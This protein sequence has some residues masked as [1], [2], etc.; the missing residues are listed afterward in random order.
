MRISLPDKEKNET[1]FKILNLLE[2]IKAELLHKVVFI[3]VGLQWN[4]NND[5]LTA[6]NLA[7]LGCV[8]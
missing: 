5:R 7:S 3:P 4:C 1:V 8:T 6:I 2:K